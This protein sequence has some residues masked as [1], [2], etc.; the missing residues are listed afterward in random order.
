MDNERVNMSDVLHTMHISS[1]LN[2][3]ICVYTATK[4]LHNFQFSFSISDDE[5]KYHCMQHISHGVNAQ[6]QRIK[7]LQFTLNYTVLLIGKPQ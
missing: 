4:E 2:Y 7:S 1:L 3:A 6:L 5:A